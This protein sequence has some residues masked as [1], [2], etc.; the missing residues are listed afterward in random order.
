MLRTVTR[1][2]G[3][4]RIALT[5]LTL[6]GLTLTVAPPAHTAPM[7][8][9]SRTI[10]SA[11]S[12]GT[13]AYVPN[14][15]S[16]DVKVIDTESNIVTAT[17]NVPGGPRR[18]AASPDGTIVYVTSYTTGTLRGI[19]TANHTVTAPVSTGRGAQDLAVTP[20]GSRL[21]VTNYL[22]K[23]LS[24]VDTATRTV[25]ATLP[26]GVAANDI[27]LSPD[28]ARLYLTERER[29]TILD[30]ASGTVV[31]RITVPASTPNRIGFAP[32]GTRAYVSDMA[33]HVLHVIDTATETV[34]STIPVQQRPFDVAVT[35]DGTRALVARNG[36]NTVADVELATASVTASIPVGTR[37]AALALS[38]D[39]TRAYVANGA[40]DSVSV[41]DTTTDTAIATVRVGDEPGDIAL[42]TPPAADLGLTLTATPRPGLTRRVDYTLTASNHGPGRL[43]DA[44][45][46]A[47]LPASGTTS[48]DCTVAG[49]TATCAVTDLAPG[50]SV[51]H[52]FTTPV[53][54]LSLGTPYTLTVT[55]TAGSPADPNPGNDTASRTCTALTPLIINCA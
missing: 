46:T 37:P 13:L 35:P 31:K 17:I 50:D 53:A 36:N 34:T 47:G 16:N 14:R 48:P 29:I 42:V 32:D 51:T 15:I 9:A 33:T 23:N 5:A 45:V 26:V 3:P 18:A 24:V 38:A 12:A 10:A 39:G 25:T 11:A 20:D 28:G 21:Y 44:T 30:T 41:I 55:R 54:L 1:P 43:T 49:T 7:P 19:D 22:D 27:A 2:S 4:L 40:A 8:T 52:H 6:A